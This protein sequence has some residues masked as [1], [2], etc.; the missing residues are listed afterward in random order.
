MNRKIVN[1]NVANKVPEGWIFVA[2]KDSVGFDV[3]I[4]TKGAIPENIPENIVAYNTLGF[5]KTKIILPL[6]D[7]SYFGL[8]D[9]LFIRHSI[10]PVSCSK[11]NYKDFLL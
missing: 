1:F 7:S 4:N 9:G 5:Y 8:N 10:L 11:I 3:D 6:I 2:G